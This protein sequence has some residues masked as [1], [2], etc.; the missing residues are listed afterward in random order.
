MLTERSGHSK[1]VQGSDRS[2]GMVF[3]IVFLLIGLWPLLGLIT[4]GEVGTPRWWSLA[5]AGAFVAVA[6]IRP[7]LLKPINR[8]WFWIGIAMHTVVSPLIMGGVFF[9]S[10]TPIGL[11]R[12]MFVHDPL[13]LRRDPAAESYWHIKEEPRPPKDSMLRQF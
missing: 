7:A 3:A 10:V 11:L 9:L 8:V 4:G 2:Y 6:L 13:G 5:I 1:T 12:R